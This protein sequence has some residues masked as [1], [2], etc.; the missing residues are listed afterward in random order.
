MTEEISDIVDTVVNHSWSFKRKT[1]SDNSNIFWETHRTEHFRSEN[2][3]VSYFY[4][5]LKLRVEA[6]DLK[7]RLGIGVVSRLEFHLFDTNLG[8][9][10]LHNSQKVAKTDISV[11][12]KTFYLM[13]FSKMCSI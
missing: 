3:R 4:P 8:V 9:E 1:P 10:F 7:R 5:T 12:Y 11:S 13:E 6:E 2:T